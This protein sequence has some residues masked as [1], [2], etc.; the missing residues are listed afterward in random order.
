MRACID[1]LATVSVG[2]GRYGT[3]CLSGMA[4]ADP[5]Q[6]HHVAGRPGGGS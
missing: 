3:L 5:G 2:V 6:Q 1:Y 4:G